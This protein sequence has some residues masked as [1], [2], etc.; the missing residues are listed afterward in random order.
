MCNLG[1]FERT[2]DR[3]I[4]E[5]LHVLKRHAL[6]LLFLPLLACASPA[7]AQGYFEFVGS[8]RSVPDH[9]SPRHGIRYNSQGYDQP[10][11]NWEKKT[12]KMIKKHVP[13]YAINEIKNFPGA[14]DAI[15][16]WIDDAFEQTQ[17]E[18]MSCP[19]L[20][21]RASRVSPASLYVTIMPSAFLEP[22]YGIDVAGA[23]YPSTKE[24]RVL[25][26]YYIWKG[27]NTGWLRHAR[28]L[29]KWEMGNFFAVELGV[30]PEPRPAGWPC[31][32]PSR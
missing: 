23:Y 10:D 30:Q 27:P 24:I 16:S 19:S 17:A 20:A 2:T 28:D 22:Y 31:N 1:P 15:G 25:N 8:P 12:K 14:P 4:T 9:F 26:I 5:E 11:V 13:E 18:F 7:K 6:W 29:L 32:A 21:F 3:F